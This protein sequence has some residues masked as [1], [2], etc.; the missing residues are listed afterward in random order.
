MLF[1]PRQHRSARRVTPVG[2]PGGGIPR[3]ATERSHVSSAMTL[4]ARLRHHHLDRET[5]VQDW[6]A[7]DKR[8]TQFSD[9]SRATPRRARPICL[10]PRKPLPPNARSDLDGAGHDGRQHH[11][12]R[13]RRR[14]QSGE[15]ILLVT[16]APLADLQLTGIILGLGEGEVTW[17]GQG[18][19]TVRCS[20]PIR[21]RRPHQG[22]R[23]PRLRR[24]RRWQPTLL[25]DR[26]VT[27]PSA[28]RFRVSACSRVR[29]I[30]S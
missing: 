6:I 24:Q 4:E 29:A 30:P 20:S 19:S 23:G 27:K 2:R 13:R 26:P 3:L 18:K 14:H 16:A 5:Q 9:P 21:P 15:G 12:L 17:G 28:S 22:L 10:L 8:Q 1:A 25:L 11:R 7:D